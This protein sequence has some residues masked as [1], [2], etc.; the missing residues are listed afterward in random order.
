MNVKSFAV[1][2]PGIAGA[3]G[4][5]I[6]TILLI[7][8]LVTDFEGSSGAGSSDRVGVIDPAESVSTETTSV[9]PKPK[10]EPAGAKNPKPTKAATT[11]PKVQNPGATVT[12][13][14]E[15]NR[16]ETWIEGVYEWK[17]TFYSGGRSEL[18][19]RELPGFN[20]KATLTEDEDGNPVETWIEDGV[21]HVK[22]FLPN[23]K[24]NEVTSDAEPAG[25][26]KTW[27]E[28]GVT[29]EE[30]YDGYGN[31]IERTQTGTPTP[32][33]P[34]IEFEQEDFTPWDASRR[35]HYT[36]AEMQQEVERQLSEWNKYRVSKGLNPGQWDQ[37]YANEAQKWADKLAKEDKGSGRFYNTYPH[38]RDYVHRG[39]DPEYNET[40]VNI[41]SAEN[42]W[43]TDAQNLETA[44]QMFID[45]PGHNRNLLLVEKPNRPFRMGIGIAKG[46][47]DSDQNGRTPY[48]VVYK[49]R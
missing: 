1:G 28:G 10:S 45:S 7:V 29:Y 23:G 8:G 21:K 34:P 19:R 46:P 27:S 2:L 39:I 32:P 26:T 42:V 47:K 37:Q 48:Y 24:T 35:T 20:P 11:R 41:Y 9:A 44:L 13:D 30:K 6:A 38:E 25:Y 3:L 12:Y 18:T 40:Y 16:V 14:E 36:P 4:T 5:I 22:T 33:P 31:L 17:E 15:G 43:K 49:M